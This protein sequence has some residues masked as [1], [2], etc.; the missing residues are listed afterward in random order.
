MTAT[1]P[2]LPTDRADERLVRSQGIGGA[3]REFRQRLAGGDLGNVPV[4]FGIAAIAIVF[5]IQDA[6][7][8]SS[9]N[10]VN[11]TLSA[12]PYG[13]I[14]LGIVLVLLLGEIDLSVG[15]ISGLAASITAV[16]F[17]NQD[18]HLLVA[19]AAGVGAGLAIGLLYG[20]LF[21]KVGVPSFV[22]TLAGL[23][24]FYGLQLSVLG[25][26]GTINIPRES[27]L[28]EFARSRFV[29]DAVSYVLVALVS[30]AYLVSRLLVI[31]RR[32]AAGLSAPSLTLVGIKTALL[33]GGLGYLTYYLNIGRGWGYSVVAFA[34]LV[35]LV[36]VLLRR[37]RW[38]RH[39]VAV[40]G[41][42]EA[43]RRS[44]IK[45]D[46]VYISAFCLTGMF[47]AIGGLMF[48]GKLTSVSQQSGG[49]DV[50]LTAI[51]AGVIG[52]TS[53]FGGRGSAYSSLLG[54]LVLTMITSGLNRIGVDSSIRFIV[55]GAVLLLAVSI[56]SIARRT[57]A[58]RGRG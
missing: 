44:G 16:L 17:V 7:Y 57:R 19:I 42:V 31:R 13:V 11:I 6:T 56:D 25:D 8:L 49:N 48:M 1:A 46:R 30:V 55:T 45:V 50:N 51:A 37:S 24:A 28:A 9:S 36:D 39:L 10:L 21:T 35:V 4:V 52:G 12:V 41:N 47:A 32:T 5:Y 14:S 20:I 29:G 23:L 38:G 33:A 26:N 18:L 54:V 27:G 15:S 40:G 2:T 34:A 22:I 58:N 3:L 53:L 43:A